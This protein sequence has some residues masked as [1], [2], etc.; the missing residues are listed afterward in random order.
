MQPMVT[1][2]KNNSTDARQCSNR[3]MLGLAAIMAFRV[4][5]QDIPQAY[6]QEAGSLL[7]DAYL[8]PGPE[9]R[10]P[11]GYLFQLLCAFYGF[12]DSGNI[13]NATFS[14]HLQEDLRIE[15]TVTGMSM[16]FRKIKSK[17]FGIMATYV[18]DTSAVDMLKYLRLDC[19]YD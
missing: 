8:R 9:L 17:L 2:T 12:L 3:L 16:F 13:W 6:L 15:R 19:D 14:K 7:G 4:W 18:D 11:D 10:I 5:S 1:K